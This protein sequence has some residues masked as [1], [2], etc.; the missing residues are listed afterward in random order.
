MLCAGK[1]LI[2]C[3]NDDSMSSS[4]FIRT[5]LSCAPVSVSL[6]VVLVPA[7][8]GLGAS[9]LESGNG[10]ERTAISVGA[11]GLSLVGSRAVAT[12]RARSRTWSRARSRAVAGAGAR[13]KAVPG[14]RADNGGIA[15]AAVGARWSVETG[16]ALVDVPGDLLAVAVPDHLASS[17]P[18]CLESGAVGLDGPAD[19]GGDEEA[20][21]DHGRDDT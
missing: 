21:D 5:L 13:S 20:S 19:D 7:A 1:K 9:G 18:R 15:T 17:A 4:I 12:A 16:V 8:L 11:F 14:T 3:D 2:Y 6:T 10:G